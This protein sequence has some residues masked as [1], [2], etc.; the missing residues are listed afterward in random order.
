L[1]ERFKVARTASSSSRPVRNLAGLSATAASGDWATA[2]ELAEFN[3]EPLLVEPLSNGE[4]DNASAA[5]QS[6]DMTG[7]SSAYFKDR[8]PS[9]VEPTTF[10]KFLQCSSLS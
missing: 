10:R 7:T 5:N 6:I 3:A 2:A 9:S 8:M 1:N 4:A